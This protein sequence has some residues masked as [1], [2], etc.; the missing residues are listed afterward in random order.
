M[1]RNRFAIT[2]YKKDTITTKIICEGKFEHDDHHEATL[3]FLQ[4][5]IFLH[6]VGDITFPDTCSLKTVKPK[7]LKDINIQIE[8]R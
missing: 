4:N 3:A 8:D 2:T 1:K 6:R 5:K 7:I